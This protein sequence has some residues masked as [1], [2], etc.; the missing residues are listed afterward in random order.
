LVSTLAY[1]IIISDWEKFCALFRMDVSVM[2]EHKT[3][4]RGAGTDSLS[5]P[6]NQ[7]KASLDTGIPEDCLFWRDAA[8][9]PAFNRAEP[10]TGSIVKLQLI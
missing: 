1:I 2:V 10:N 8:K 7:T 6:G 5:T 9:P 3:L 4:V